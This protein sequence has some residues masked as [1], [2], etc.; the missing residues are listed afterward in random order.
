MLQRNPRP[1]RLSF[2]VDL[3]MASCL[4]VGAAAAL[5]LRL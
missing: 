4:T 2:L 3:V 1:V 5:A